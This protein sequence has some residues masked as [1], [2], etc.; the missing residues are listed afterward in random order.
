[1]HIPE[2]C[3]VYLRARTTHSN[4]THCL[5]MLYKYRWSKCGLNNFSACCFFN[6]MVVMSIMMPGC[7][8]CQ[9]NKTKV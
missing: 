7:N 2:Y 1:M 4:A 8:Y 5:V 6:Y 3:T 9:T